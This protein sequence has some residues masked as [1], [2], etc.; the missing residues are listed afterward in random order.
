MPNPRCKEKSGGGVQ[1]ARNAA[2]SSR[3]ESKDFS[4]AVASVSLTLLL[5]PALDLVTA[6]LSSVE[7][8]V[9]RRSWPIGGRN[10]GKHGPKSKT[11]QNDESAAGEVQIAAFPHACALADEGY[12]GGHEER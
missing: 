7:T 3:I 4:C 8:M 2:Y 9:S 6:S 5:A 1:H 10:C 12:Q 11:L